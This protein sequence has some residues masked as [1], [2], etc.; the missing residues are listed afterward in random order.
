MNEI[1]FADQPGGTDYVVVIDPVGNFRRIDTAV[2]EP[3]NVAN[4]TNYAESASEQGGSGIYFADAPAGIGDGTFNVVAK[5]RL[6]AT[7]AAGDP[8]V[9]AGSLSL[10]GGAI[11]PPMSFDTPDAV[12]TG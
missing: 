10:V 9:G 5:R 2:W 11:P 8:V 7:P 3:F 12:E 6:G 4:W 1:Q